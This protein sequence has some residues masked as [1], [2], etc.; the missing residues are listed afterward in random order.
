MLGTNFALIRATTK[1][2]PLRR[3][4][5]PTFT[6]FSF[7]FQKQEKIGF[8]V[9]VVHRVSQLVCLRFKIKTMNKKKLVKNVNFL[10]FSQTY[11]LTN[12]HTHTER[13]WETISLGFGPLKCNH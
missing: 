10:M 2:L 6:Q 1:I 4:V 5:P 3:K 9:C 7:K 8:I 13:E 12:T 11:A